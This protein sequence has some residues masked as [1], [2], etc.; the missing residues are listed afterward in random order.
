MS[1]LEG[2]AAATLMTLV[3][4][5]NP[6]VDQMSAML[7]K[8]EIVIVEIHADSPMKEKVEVVEVKLDKSIYYSQ[9]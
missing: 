2:I 7:S 1:V 4:L 5:D 3:V 9:M 8:G 6:E